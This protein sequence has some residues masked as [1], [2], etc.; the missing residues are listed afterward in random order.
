M[1]VPASLYPSLQQGCVVLASS[2]KKAVALA[3]VEFL[4]KPETVDLLK[5]YGFG[6]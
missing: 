6:K 5:A 1:E 3:F 4:K 2:K